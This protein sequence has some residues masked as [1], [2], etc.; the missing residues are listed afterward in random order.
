[1]TYAS[2]GNSRHETFCVSDYDCFKQA[3]VSLQF[4]DSTISS[5]IL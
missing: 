4:Y 2:P 5:I 3:E 1:M